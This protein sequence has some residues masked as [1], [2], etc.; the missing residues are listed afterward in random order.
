MIPT[1]Q[2]DEVLVEAVE[3]DER[4]LDAPHALARHRLESRPASAHEREL[5]GHEQAVDE[6]QDEQEDEK[7]SAHRPAGRPT[8]QRFALCGRVLGGWS[9]SL[10]GPGGA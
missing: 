3:L 9:S 6:H 1:W 5:S 10:I 4:G 8:G 7:E 2:A